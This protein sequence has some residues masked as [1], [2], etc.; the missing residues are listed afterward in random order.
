MFS[1]Q[2][3]SKRN[4]K[5]TDTLFFLRF[6]GEG[7]TW[8]FPAQNEVLDSCNL[9]GCDPKLTRVKGKAPGDFSEF[10]MKP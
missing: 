7:V 10:W 9:A 8:F 2:S 5:G 6:P 4:K 1:Y 3:Q